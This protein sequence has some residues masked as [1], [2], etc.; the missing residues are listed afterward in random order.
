MEKTTISLPLPLYQ[1]NSDFSVWTKRFEA[2]CKLIKAEEASKLEMLFLCFSGKKFDD[3]FATFDN[4]TTF[5][6]A[7]TKLEELIVKE[8]RPTDPLGYF[9]SRKWDW[10]NETIYD[11]HREL[12][13]RVAHLVTASKSRDELVKLQIARNAP[14]S[15]R[16]FL[17]MNETMPINDLLSG[18]AK[19]CIVV[20]DD[21]SAHNTNGSVCAVNSGVNKQS[22]PRHRESNGKSK[23]VC[24]YCGKQNHIAANCFRNPRSVSFKGTDQDQKNA[25]LGGSPN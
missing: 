3:L 11:Y 12:S 4:K 24:F 13:K 19:M 16:N 6:S 20:D 1:P 17:I 2:Y 25:N 22:L 5:N 18:I 21:S 8:S 23:I 7:L 9:T 15:A 10:Q 14:A